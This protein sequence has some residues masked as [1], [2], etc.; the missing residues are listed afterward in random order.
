MNGQH[1]PLRPGHCW[2]PE[3]LQTETHWYSSVRMDI[4]ASLLTVAWVLPRSTSSRYLARPGSDSAA[5]KSALLAR[6][7]SGPTTQLSRSNCPT[8]RVVSTVGVLA[9]RL[10]SKL[11]ACFIC[12]SCS[13]LPTC[14]EGES[15]V[16]F[17]GDPSED[18]FPASSR[19]RHAVSVKLPHYTFVAF[20]CRAPNSLRP[21]N[22]Q[23]RRKK[24]SIR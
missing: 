3:L 14:S 15:V 24:K 2:R 20:H 11:S 22:K 19:V 6:M 18:S 9:S 12:S 13:S 21:G 7:L 1:C 10:A 5:A 4:I 16:D 8:A 17:P 23:C